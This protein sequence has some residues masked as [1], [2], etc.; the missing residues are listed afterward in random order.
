[1]QLRR[2]RVATRIVVRNAGMIWATP[3][4]VRNCGTVSGEGKVLD[5]ARKRAG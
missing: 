3:S 2:G 4:G 1:M 5:T